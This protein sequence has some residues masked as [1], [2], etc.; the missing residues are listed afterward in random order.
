MSIRIAQKCRWIVFEGHRLSFSSRTLIKALKAWG[1]HKT[2]RRENISLK[3]LTDIQIVCVC[4]IDTAIVFCGFSSLGCRLVTQFQK[5][6]LPPS[7][8]NYPFHRRGTRGHLRDSSA[9]DCSH[10][11]SGEAVCR[12]D[13]YQPPMRSTDVCV[14]AWVCAWVCGAMRTAS[15][16]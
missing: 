11:S 1:A 16:Y 8:N 15:A 4:R 3:K 10:L 7:F 13:R 14:C 5:S 2:K 9:I 12:T 6:F